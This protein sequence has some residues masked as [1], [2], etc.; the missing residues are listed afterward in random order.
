MPDM[1]K[2]VIEVTPKGIAEARKQLDELAASAGISEKKTVTLMDRFRSMQSVMQ[3][4]VAALNEVGNM[5]KSVYAAGK[6][7]VDI[8]GVQERAVS[9]LEAV[10]KSTGGTVGKTSKELQ[11]MAARLQDATTFGDEAIINM[12]AVL[13][14]F[15]NISG[16]QF[17]RT[18]KA[19][20]DMST[21]M[22]TDLT[23]AANMLGKALDSPIEGM[24]TLSRV[25]FIFTEDQKNLVEELQQSGDLLGAQNVILGEVEK[26]FGGASTAAGQ[27]ATGAIKK[28]EN[29]V[30]DFKEQLG[31]AI[32]EGMMP[33]NVALRGMVDNATA[34][35]KAQN[36]LNDAYKAND[37]GTATL[38]QQL[39]ILQAHRDVQKQTLDYL[40]QMA[41]TSGPRTVPKEALQAFD[42]EVSEENAQIALMAR[43]IA[44][45]AQGQKAA[46]EAEAKRLKDEQAANE[47]RLKA[48][49]VMKVKTD[50]ANGKDIADSYLDNLM[51]EVE[52]AAWLGDDI[53]GAL[54]KSHNEIRSTI[55]TLLDSGLF[56]EKD[57]MI[58]RL[59]E[60]YEIVGKLI[61]ENSKKDQAATEIEVS[62][63][64]AKTEAIKDTTSAREAKT[65]A[66][67]RAKEEAARLKLAEAEENESLREK[68]QILQELESRLK[69]VTNA[70]D[71]SA[72]DAY[73]TSFSEIGKALEKGSLS[74][75]SFSLAMEKIG[76]DLLN[77]LPRLF[78]AAGLQALVAQ[79]WELGIGLIVAS[80]FTA[81]FAGY[82]TSAYDEKTSKSQATKS[83]MGNIFG[84]EGMQTFAQGGAFTNTIVTRPTLFSYGGKFLGEM[85][86]AGPE[87]VVPLT[88]MSNGNLGVDAKP[89]NVVVQIIDQTSK[90]TQKETQETTSPDGTKVLTV[91]IR[92]IVTDQLSNGGLD[93]PMRS[94]YGLNAVGVRRS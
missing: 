33:F 48:A 53:S 21:V 32:A 76:L 29:S 34:A 52:R 20:L 44:M 72:M 40:N 87:A 61:D 14:G 67:E 17:E 85:G 47:W 82:A 28:L 39:L 89:S 81:I 22:G 2:L 88:R 51:K 37:R 80:G 83:A 60:N 42:K 90:G 91:F 41:S 45:N 1:A 3:G 24:S 36:D 11:D 25:G 46:S 73:V 84:W 58:T 35:L 38:Q 16:D 12:N 65:E 15:R 4:P 30:G 59:R 43:A 70:I 50:T 31:R 13:L 68:Y 74:G 19:V 9:N 93:L 7:L 63:N 62:G 8:Y 27:L 26:A 5:M 75:E 23:S 55:Y 69:A 79:Q 94:R 71:Q 57:M 10:L 6:E 54:E 78:L 56:S 49:E 18:T 66:D 64:K 86:E 77:L 92:D